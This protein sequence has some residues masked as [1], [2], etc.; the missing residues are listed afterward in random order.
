[1]P[2]PF[3]QPEPSL[4]ADQALASKVNGAPAVIY[5]AKDTRRGRQYR[6]RFGD[7]AAP[8]EKWFTY[9]ILV[10]YFFVLDSPVT[11]A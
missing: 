4:V 5:A 10:L 8:G 2:L 7:Q 9:S 6:V 3:Q 1:M 11:D